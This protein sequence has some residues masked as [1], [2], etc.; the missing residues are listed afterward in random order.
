MKKA[1]DS[2]CMGTSAIRLCVFFLIIAVLSKI[3]FD[4]DYESDDYVLLLILFRRM[5]SIRGQECHT[6]DM[7]PRVKSISGYLSITQEVVPY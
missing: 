3:R 7:V 6:K 2:V 4:A 5:I 1:L